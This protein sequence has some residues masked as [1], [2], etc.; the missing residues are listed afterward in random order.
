MVHPGPHPAP[1]IAAQARL[2]HS[3]LRLSLAL[4][5]AHAAQG[6]T[7]A[8]RGAGAAP[9]WV[10]GLTSDPALRMVLQTVATWWAHHPLQQATSVA[11]LAAREL[12]RPMALRNPFGLVLGAAAVGGALVL[13]KPWR[14]ISVSALAAGLVPQLLAKLVAQLRPASWA[15]VLSSWLRADRPNGA[16]ETHGPAP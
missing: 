16:N 15:E 8:A 5:Q 4:H 3:R 10:E 14:W 13:I 6:Q 7:D 2:N 1:F 9:G 11:A 12:L